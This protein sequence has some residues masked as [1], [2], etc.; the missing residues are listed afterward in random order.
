MKNSKKIIS[1]ILTVFMCIS[2]MIPAYAETNEGDPNEESLLTIESLDPSSLGVE[3]L[4]IVDVD[5][6]EEL[7]FDF[8]SD[9]IVRVSIVLDKPSTIDAG[10]ST[11]DIGK[12]KKAVSYRESLKQQQAEVN[13]RIEKNLSKR[14]NVKWNLTLAVNIISAEVE[15]GDINKI[16]LISGVKDVIMENRYEAIN[17]STSEPNTSNTSGYI[18]GAVSAWAD[19]YTGAGSR[20]AIIDTG[21]D[22]DHQSVNA[23]AF[24]Y[25]IS[26]L[27]KKPVLMKASDI[28]GLDLNGNG[29]YVSTKILYAYNYV[30]NNSTNINHLNDTQGE[31]GSHVAGIVQQIGILRA[32]TLMLKPFLL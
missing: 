16:R 17:N 20:I 9:D 4:G 3:K 30:D 8:N 28:T 31:H 18:V 24:D 1:I 26:Q 7:T 14:I 6:E 23:D 15:Y 13:N 2:H 21:L 19:G 25:A 12:D 10:Y 22:T 27:E 11:K 5:D 29:K 32:E